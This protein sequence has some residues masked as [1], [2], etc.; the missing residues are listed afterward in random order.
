MIAVILIILVLMNGIGAWASPQPGYY[1]HGWGVLGLICLI[2]LIILLLK[3][4][5]LH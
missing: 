4:E 2:L 1:R 3:P 5:L